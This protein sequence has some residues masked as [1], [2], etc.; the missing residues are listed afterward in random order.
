MRARNVGDDTFHITIGP[1]DGSGASM[2]SLMDPPPAESAS[3]S[4]NPLLAFNHSKDPFGF[5]VSRRTHEGAGD[6]PARLV[7]TAS[8]GGLV[9]SEQ[10]V[11]LSL[12]LSKDANVFGLGEHVSEQLRVN[13]TRNTTV[14]MWTRD[15][16]TPV[17]QEFN[18]YGSHP[19]AL[20]MEPNGEAYGVLFLSA[21]AID[22]LATPFPTLTY[23]TIGGG[24][25]LVPVPDP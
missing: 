5:K 20:V 23:R 6:S 22:F 9:V 10:Y 4:A 3:P 7:D 19:F 8:V 21:T 1:V 15:Q 12:A 2:A 11:S 16:A 13:V 18:L 17:G 25:G 14:T 24:L